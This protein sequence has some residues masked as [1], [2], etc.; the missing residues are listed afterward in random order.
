MELWDYVATAIHNI[1]VKQALHTLA[2]I[3][4]QQIR[5]IILGYLY[6]HTLL[7]GRSMHLTAS[8]ITYLLCLKVWLMNINYGSW[9]VAPRRLPSNVSM[10]LLIFIHYALILHDVTQL[11]TFARFYWPEWI[12]MESRQVKEISKYIFCCCPYLCF[13]FIVPLM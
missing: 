10:T 7:T 4:Q 9:L 5:Y 3:W 12:G 11:Q 8:K 2:L 13:R 1:R 6:S